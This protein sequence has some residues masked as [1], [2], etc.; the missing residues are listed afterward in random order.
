MFNIDR[1]SFWYSQYSKHCIVTRKPADE[2]VCYETPPS[3]VWNPVNNAEYYLL[4]VYPSV[5]RKQNRSFKTEMNIHTPAMI[6]P[7]GRYFWQVVAFGKNDKPIYQTEVYKFY[8]SAAA[9]K[10]PFPDMKKLA[11]DFPARH[12]CL[13]FN[14]DELKNAVIDIKQRHPLFIKKAVLSCDGLAGKELLPEPQRLPSKRGIERERIISRVYI[15]ATRRFLEETELLSLGHVLT[16][17]KDYSAEAKKRILHICSWDLKG[18][19]NLFYVDEPSMGIL[20][21]MPLCFDLLFDHFSSQERKQVIDNLFYRTADVMKFLIKTRTP[22]FH[23]DPSFN[24]S[25]RM[26]SLAGI[27]LLSVLNEKKEAAVYLDYIL[28]LLFAIYPVWGNDDG[29][30]ANGLFYWTGY[31]LRMH[32]FLYALKHTTGVDLYKKRF[33]ENNAY[34][35]VYCCPPCSRFSYFSDGYNSGPASRHKKTAGG[36]ETFSNLLK[37]I[38][39]YNAHIYH[40]GIIKHFDEK[41]EGNV[42]LNIFSILPLISKVKAKKAFS[43]PQSRYYSDSGWV[44]M[45]SNIK[46]PGRDIFIMMQSSPIGS[47]SHSHG[48]QNCFCLDVFGKNMIVPSGYYSF[49]FDR[50][51]A[52]WTRQTIA[53]NGVLINGKGQRTMPPDFTSRGKI[54]KVFFTEHLDYTC[55]D[56]SD[57]Y[58]NNLELWKRHILFFKPYYALVYDEIECLKKSTITWL[59]HTIAR[60]EIRAGRIT[61]KQDGICLL[62][63]FLSPKFLRITQTDKFRYPP[64]KKAMV[65]RLSNPMSQWHVNITA[66]AK[67]RRIESI[68]LLYPYRQG[69]YS[70]ENALLQER[71]D[72]YLLKIKGRG[73]E[74]RIELKRGAAKSG[75]GIFNAV[76]KRAAGTVYLKENNFWRI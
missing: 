15:G 59:L 76:C 67:I 55:G 19:T 56:A 9:K 73:F 26:I 71:K 58:G 35:P 30:W 12:P 69:T 33:F 27:S 10:L 4:L 72:S 38:M 63:K 45:H 53:A 23:V 61:I 74:D 64:S 5:D 65:S 24:H 21:H 51:H 32:E 39:G 44:A 40:D 36:D 31:I 2:K 6:F 1:N 57:S 25:I 48:H 17:N 49:W 20:R 52:R 46:E 18:T 54:E 50:H 47:F 29:G 22:P 43:L 66:P 37:R 70:L 42:P 14:S 8:V 11:G 60:N 41:L 16:G 34:L 7:S 28:K 3:F 62:A 13:Y 75:D 68:L